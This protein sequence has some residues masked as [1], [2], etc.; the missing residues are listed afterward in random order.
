MRRPRISG[1]VA[2]WCPTLWGVSR[3]RGLA[4]RVAAPP[5]PLTFSGDC[6]FSRLC[7]W[8]EELDAE[9]R[10][11]TRGALIE[12]L[13]QLDPMN[14]VSL[15][16]L[17]IRLE[18]PWIRDALSP[19]AMQSHLQPI[20]YLPT[21]RIV[22]F[23]ALARSMVDG[24]MRSGFELVRASQTHGLEPWF[25]Q[26]AAQAALQQG[27]PQILPG[28]SLF[29]NVTPT[30]LADADRFEHRFLRPMKKAGVDLTQI[31]FEMIETS[32]LPPLSQLMATVGRLRAYGAS[33]AVD[34]LGAGCNAYTCI[35]DIEPDVVKL[36]RSLLQLEEASECGLIQSLTA[37]AHSVGAMVV[38][39]GIECE[40][41]LQIAVSAEVD[42]GQGW[43]IGR[44]AA[45]ADRTYGDRPFLS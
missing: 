7:L 24:V 45:K 33:L 44:P 16:T 1:G 2:V 8:L 18:T 30:T 32:E 29:L 22:A 6:W 35:L 34:D 19:A 4:D 31:V 15:E 20:V 10:S 28:E 40:E 36:D 25:E 39:E 17:M 11:Q 41:H 12:D 14:T 27:L 37:C 23:E 38:A 21:G 42:M 43:H 9:S 26:A 13:P 3:A 5:A